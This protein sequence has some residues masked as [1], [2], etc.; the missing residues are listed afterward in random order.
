MTGCWISQYLRN[1]AREEAPHH[2]AMD[3]DLVNAANGV[4]AMLAALERLLA[5]A[6]FDCLDD[7]SNVWR[8]NMLD[9]RAAI[10]R[11][12]GEV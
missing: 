11:A 9:A 1:R 8:S 4:D 2:G 6:E 7:K 5:V 10:A 3:P 12:R